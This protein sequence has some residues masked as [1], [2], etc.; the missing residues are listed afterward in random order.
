[1]PEGGV[2]LAQESGFG[3]SRLDLQVA[4]PRLRSGPGRRRRLE[5]APFR[6]RADARDVAPSNLPALGYLEDGHLVAHQM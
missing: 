5:R 6:H 3:P 1:M 2:A 4:R